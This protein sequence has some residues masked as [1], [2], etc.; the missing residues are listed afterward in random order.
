[1]GDAKQAAVSAMV[2]HIKDEA[3][4]KCDEIH[5]QAQQTY[6]VEKTKLVQ[7][8]SDKAR[9]EHTVNMKK[10]ETQR[11]ISRSTQ[12]NK[13]RLKKVA[14]RAAYLEKSCDTVKEQMVALTKD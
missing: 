4:K 9:K 7:E 5:A 12:I 14:E 11:A 2:K 6:A 1:M 13:S 10:I 8:L 3:K